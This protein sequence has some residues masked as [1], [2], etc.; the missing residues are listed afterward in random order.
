MGVRRGGRGG[1]GPPG[2]SYMISLMCFSTSTRIVKTSQLSPTI[3]VLSSLLRR[4]T[5][6]GVIE[7]KWDQKAKFFRTKMV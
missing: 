3:L 5:E 2:F 4:L 7:V 6:E 1:R